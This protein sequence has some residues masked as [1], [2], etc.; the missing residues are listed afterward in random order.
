MTEANQVKKGKN[1]NKPE[2][3]SS[4]VEA[5]FTIIQKNI[6]VSGRFTK[7]KRRLFTASEKVKP[8]PFW[9]GGKN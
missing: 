2:I 9:K 6:P 8:P 7:L 4:N 3:G 1:K 5:T